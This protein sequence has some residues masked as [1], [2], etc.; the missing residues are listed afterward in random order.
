VDGLVA[1]PNGILR[2]SWLSPIIRNN[3]GHLGPIVG[4]AAEFS[5]V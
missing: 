1:A 5:F 3:S 4:S 2:G